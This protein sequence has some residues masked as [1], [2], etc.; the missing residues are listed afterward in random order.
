MGY[1][2]TRNM[3]N[4]NERMISQ[5]QYI[6]HPSQLD[7]RLSSI[8]STS[9]PLPTVPAASAAAA[10]LAAS[11]PTTTLSNNQQGKKKYN[12]FLDVIISKKVV[13]GVSSNFCLYHFWLVLFWSSTPQGP[14]PIKVSSTPTTPM[15]SPAPSVGV[16]MP[17]ALSR[18]PVNPANLQHHTQ[19]HVST[20]KQIQSTNL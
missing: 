18:P 1:E 19:S 4:S 14:T 20:F 13:A 9:I 17:T 15:V 2:T 16:S 11:S 12:K 3:N 10:V 7:S 6:I 8:P 5:P